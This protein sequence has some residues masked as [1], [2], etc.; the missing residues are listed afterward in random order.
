[1]SLYRAT[2]SCPYGLNLS[3][4][5]LLTGNPANQSSCLSVWKEEKKGTYTV[6]YVRLGG[7]CW[8]HCMLAFPVPGPASLAMQIGTCKTR[9]NKDLHKAGE[10]ERKVSQLW[11]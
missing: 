5:Q 2:I 11:L 6:L 8:Y 4:Q 7:Q 1:M 3:L 9:V 10:K